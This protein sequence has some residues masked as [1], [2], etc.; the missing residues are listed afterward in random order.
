MSEEAAE[1]TQP[2]A[3]LDEILSSSRTDQEKFSKLFE[4][5]SEGDIS[6]KN[7]VDSL[8]HLVIICV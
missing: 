1:Y 4:L 6:N 8:L 5:I 7:V 3:S 2:D